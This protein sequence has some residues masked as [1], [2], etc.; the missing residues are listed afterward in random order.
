MSA[1]VQPWLLQPETFAQMTHGLSGHRS[2]WPEMLIQFN[3]HDAYYT[4]TC[5]CMCV[6]VYIYSL[7]DTEDLRFVLVNEYIQ[8]N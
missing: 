7:E 6:C 1:F 3:V 8:C 5:I 4:V 2:V